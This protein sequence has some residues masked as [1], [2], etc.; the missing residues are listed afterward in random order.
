MAL[1]RG[2][3]NLPADEPDL[4]SSASQISSFIRFCE[5]R[6]GDNFASYLAFHAFSIAHSDQFWS[7]FLDWS[8]LAHEGSQLPVSTS[9]QC[10]TA[11][12]FPNLRLNYAESLLRSESPAEAQRG[13]IVAHGADAQPTRLTRGELRSRVLSVASHLRR[14]GVR[15]GDRVVAVA[16]NNAE[17]VISALAAATLGA[18]FSSAS[19]E[20]GVAAVLSRFAQLRP[21]VL[22]AN[23]RANST[24]GPRALADQI[25]QIILG[26]P[27]LAMLITLDDGALPKRLGMPCLRLAD[28]ADA[29]GLEVGEWIRFALNQPL[30]ALFTSGTTGRPKCLVHGAGGTLLEHVKEHRLHV[31]LRPGD[32]LFFHTTAAWMMWNWQLSALASG[33]ELVL[34]DGSVSDPGTL[35]EL[36]QRYDVN[37]LVR[38]R[39]T[40]SCARTWTTRRRPCRI[41]GR[42]SVPDRSSMTGSM[43]G[44]TSGWDQSPYSRSPEAPT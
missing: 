39:P 32:R 2:R 22:M 28:L 31:D 24:T 15:P 20:M 14:L 16:G 38:A 33:A 35:W 21:T 40:C 25:E 44:C 43:T 18:V 26:L 41:C 23:L 6:T 13:A 4:S 10:E 42:S 1:R 29:E 37:V 30:Y 17:A 34:Y 11:Q 12:F 8:R 9:D 3:S 7:A 27:S 19:P 36:A 5:L